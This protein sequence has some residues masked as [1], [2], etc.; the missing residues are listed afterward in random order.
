MEIN[1][2]RRNLEKRPCAALLFDILQNHATHLAHSTILFDFPVYKDFDGKPISAQALIVAPEFGLIIFAMV[3]SLSDVNQAMENLDHV[4][5]FIHSRLIR[6][7]RLK[8]GITELVIPLN[9]SLFTTLSNV[10]ISETDIDLIYSSQDF[11]EYLKVKALPTPL[12]E[13]LFAE[14]LSTLE[15]SK[16]LIR[17]KPREKT[18][19]KESKGYFVQ[20]LEDEIRLFDNRQKYGFVVP[21]DGPER[22]RGIAGSGKTVVLAMKAAVTHLTFPDANIVY[23]FYTKSLYQHV[24]RLITRFYRQ[25]DDK[26][27]NWNT[28]RVM[29]AWGGRSYPGVYYETCRHHNVTPSTF[30]DKRNEAL[31]KKTSVFDVVCTE[32]KQN[33]S[34]NPIYDFMFIDEGQDFPASFIDLCRQISEKG[35]IVWAYDELQNIFNIKTPTQEEVFGRNKDGS[36]IAEIFEDVVLYK[37]YRNPR[38]I[39]TTAHALGFGIY[40][41][42]IVQMFEDKE[43]WEDT[44]YKV[45]EG[46]CK[47]G[48]ITVVERPEETGTR[49]I[50]SNF[51]FDQIVQCKGFGTVDDEIAFVVEEIKKDISS[52]LRPDDIV[53]SI[54]DDRNAKKYANELEKLLTKNGIAANNTH[55]D[56]FGIVDFYIEGE[57]T[58]STVHKA[59]GNEAYKVYVIGVDAIFGYPDIIS[60]NRIFT[61]ITRAKAWVTITGVGHLANKCFEEIEIVAKHFPTL[62][63]VYP[64]P[65]DIRI[66]RRDMTKAAKKR[67]AAERAIDEALTMMSPEEIR[68]YLEQIKK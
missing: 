38:E 39:L 65:K 1:V 67:L 68:Q 31:L 24:K 36:P 18:T 66:M 9:Y 50:S 43:H 56:S 33:Y 10:K 27:P 55:Q 48:E 58:I 29:H 42:K 14:L 23:T 15:G 37:S 19:E 35:R 4:A 46:T 60:R 16:G 22:I 17:P 6:N 20:L 40:S 51:S 62:K 3:D 41:D 21:S 64:S 59:K 47:P 8:A 25:F 28:L 45:L 44:G 53:I 63:F 7:T 57:V 12:T 30:S 34:L 61:A 13:D 54:V 5:G 26:D 11:S 52:G 2:R 49:T 32:L